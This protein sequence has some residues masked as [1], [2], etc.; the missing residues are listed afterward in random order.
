MNRSFVLVAERG[1]VLHG[2]VGV[3]VIRLFAVLTGVCELRA[4]FLLLLPPSDLLARCL[5]LV[6]FVLGDAAHG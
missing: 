3:G 4:C 2:V 1:V 5:W 6:V